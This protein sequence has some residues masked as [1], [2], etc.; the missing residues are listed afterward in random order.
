MCEKSK[1]TTIPLDKNLLKLKISKRKKHL[2]ELLDINKV[3]KKNRSNSF[4]DVDLNISKNNKNSFINT[5]N[6]SI[7][8]YY[9]NNNSCTGSALKKKKNL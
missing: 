6:N 4:Y 8:N 2:F 9:K 7:S 1:V 5:I 3:K